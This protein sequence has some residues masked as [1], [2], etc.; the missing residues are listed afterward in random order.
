MTDTQQVTQLVTPEALRRYNIFKGAIPVL[1]AALLLGL[2][3]LNRQYG[4]ITAPTLTNPTG[5]IAPGVAN[6]EGQGTAGSTI[7]VQ[8]NGESIGTAVVAA[9]GTWSLETADLAPG[10]YQITADAL[11]PDGTIRGTADTL[12]FS[13]AAPIAFVP[14]TLTLPAGDI[15]PAQVTLSGEGTPGSTIELYQNGDLVGTTLVGEDGTWSFDTVID[16][17]NNEFEAVGLTPDGAEIGRAG[18]LA[19]VVPGAAAALTVD[20]LQLGNFSASENGRSI[21]PITLSGTGEP[22][23]QV[24]LF[25]N[26]LPIGTADI[27]P[28]GTWT[29]TGDVD[30]PPGDYDLEV[31]MLAT[32]GTA[33]ASQT[34]SG[35]TVPDLA[36]SSAITL[37]APRFDSSTG[38]VTLSGTALPGETVEIVIDGEVVDTTI[39]DADRNW[40]IERRFLAGAYELQARSADDTANVS[41]SLDYVME[42]FV[43]LS[44]ERSDDNRLTLTGLALPD[45]EV[46]IFVDGELVG[47]AVADA[48]G[49]W[50]FTTEAL[51]DGRYSV[52]ARIVDD[53]GSSIAEA[54]DQ[55]SVGAVNTTLTLTYSSASESEAESATGVAVAELAGTPAVAL[56]LD[57]SWSMQAPFGGGTRFTV[58]QE[59]VA[60]IVTEILPPSSA[61]VLRA[62]GNI[63]GNYACRTDLMVPYQPLDREAFNDVLQDIAP[64]FNANTPI[65]ASLALVA[66]DLADATEE[67]RIIV[68]LTDGEETC[69]G[70]P[71]TA[72]QALVDAGFNVQVNIVGLAIADEALKAEFERWAEIGGGQ[73]FDV[74]E[75]GEL[76]AALQAATGAF[77]TVLDA[78]GNVVAEG[79]VGG[80]AVAVDPGTYTIEV[81]TSPMTVIEAVVVEEGEAVE[82]TL[83]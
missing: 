30:L 43:T 46:Q 29:F 62:F 56:I 53:S 42:P 38:L 82:I 31:R 2:I 27:G 61:V 39:A 64:Q 4:R 13:V 7:D 11:D 3:G 35:L 9:D 40:S 77:Y 15:D 20:P 19:L 41:S 21:G 81:N 16:R 25:L 74:T 70:D 79:R 1:L 50:S 78:D 45:S 34:A 5:E 18:P 59:A 47:T 52:E 71:A 66:D 75:P 37:D 49:R 28:D 54:S 23:T 73:Y 26:G 72:I 76:G 44:S 36:I 12:A 68:L 33:L 8:L 10:S 17:L 60:T 32:D 55:A 58:A 57:A 22:N 65:A 14:P 69:D 67:E 24:G 83:R 48:D 80:T 63:E 51:A 6:I